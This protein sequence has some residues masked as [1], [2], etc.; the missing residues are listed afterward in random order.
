MMSVKHFAEILGI[1]VWD[2]D[3]CFG[4]DPIVLT[5]EQRRE[6]LRERLRLKNKHEFLEAMYF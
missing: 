4:A 3:W 1:E 6:V 5:E 2:G